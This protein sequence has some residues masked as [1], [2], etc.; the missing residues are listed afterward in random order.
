MGTLVDLMHNIGRQVGFH[1]GHAVDRL[2]YRLLRKGRGPRR[3][4]L[5]SFPRSG[6]TWMR[7]LIESATGQQTGSLYTK[8][9]I[10]P[11]DT[12]GVVIKTHGF[13]ACRFTHAIHLVRHPMDA[14]ASYYRWNKD[15]RSG[16]PPEWG[17]FLTDNASYWVLH[18]EHWLNTPCVTRR[19][20][21]E[22]LHRNPVALLLETCQWLGFEANEDLC[23]RAVEACSMER[24]RRMHGETGTR[25]FRKGE[26]GASVEMFSDA[27]RHLLAR[28][29]GPIMKRLGYDILP[30]GT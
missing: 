20:R 6:N 19:I 8:D 22:D 25:F 12:E 29:A 16:S 7:S 1:G 17:K 24:L 4:A 28:R 10:M 3:V 13:D 27:Q 15:F 18:T 9:R 14:I 30:P 2:F 26:I 11:R 23:R 5:A 21:Y